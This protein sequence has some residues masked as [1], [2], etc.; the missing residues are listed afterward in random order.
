MNV[1][2]RLDYEDTLC[3]ATSYSKALQRQASIDLDSCAQTESLR[4]V[5]VKHIPCTPTPWSKFDNAQSSSNF[6]ST[7][8][9]VS[10]LSHQMAMQNK[11]LGLGIRLLI[12]I[13]DSH[14]STQEILT[15]AIR[16]LKSSLNIKTRYYSHHLLHLLLANLRLHR[17]P[18][19]S[20]SR[21]KRTNLQWR[22]VISSN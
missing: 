10:D 6:I 16:I 7:L 22:L 21:L 12:M 5:L 20:S 15:S 9:M 4:F 1:W 18:C 8:L 2:T 13:E 19:C 11:R 3:Y 17:H 14:F